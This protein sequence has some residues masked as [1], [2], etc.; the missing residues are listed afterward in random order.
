MLGVDKMT[1][2]IP[3]LCKTNLS[4]NHE[5]HEFLDLKIN[6]IKLN[7]DKKLPFRKSIHDFYITNNITRASVVMSK[8]SSIYNNR[9]NFL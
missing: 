3:F 8:C 9:D 5:K 2:I 6:K 4:V 7:L 1:S